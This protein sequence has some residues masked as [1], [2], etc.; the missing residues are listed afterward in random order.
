MKHYI[1]KFNVVGMTFRIKENPEIANIRPKV[2]QRVVFQKDSNNKYS[3]TGKA[4]KIFWNGLHIGYVPEKNH[5]ELQAEIFD[6]IETIEGVIKWVGY[7]N[8]EKKD[9]AN[10]TGPFNSLIINVF[11]LTRNDIYN[12]APVSEKVMVP[13]FNEPVKVELLDNH[14]FYKNIQLLSPSTYKKRILPEF[15]APFVAKRCAPGY[16]MTVKEI[17]DMWDF[18]GNVASTFGE[19]IDIALTYFFK[20]DKFG[21]QLLDLGKK[22]VNIAIPKHPIIKN[23]VISFLETFDKNFNISYKNVFPQ[24][25]CTDVKNNMCGIIDNLVVHDIENKV[26]SIIDYKAQVDPKKKMREYEIQLSYYAK[27]LR[28]TGWTIK[29]LYIYLL[30]ETW[31]SLSIKEVDIIL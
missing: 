23:I 6:N 24:V 28:N 3:K 29:G 17:V 7:K 15:N 12:M 10:G 30:K 4:V 14:Y 22:D 5:E 25:L 19:A 8:E 1:T 2:F 20:Y 13:S 26:C 11:D 21:R 16:K 31:E 27:I 9:S 18:Y